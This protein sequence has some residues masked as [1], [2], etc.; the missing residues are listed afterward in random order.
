MKKRL[1]GKDWA[2]IAEALQMLSMDYLDEH[3]DQERL[4]AL[5]DLA[6]LKADLN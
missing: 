2:L 3:P 1:T 5:E 4:D 6:T